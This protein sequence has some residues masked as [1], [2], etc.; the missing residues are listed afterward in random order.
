MRTP[1]STCQHLLAPQRDVKDPPCANEKRIAAPPPVP[2][3]LSV[4]TR[5]NTRGQM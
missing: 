4:P 1:A 2:A 3:R 5:L